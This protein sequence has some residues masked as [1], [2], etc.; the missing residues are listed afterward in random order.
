MRRSIFAA[1]PL[2]SLYPRRQAACVL[3]W[4]ILV[5]TQFGPASGQTQTIFTDADSFGVIICR[6]DAPFSYWCDRSPGS[7]QYIL[8][9][10]Q[11]ALMAGY[12]HF[13]LSGIDATSPIEEARLQLDTISNSWGETTV[14]VFAIADSTADWD[15]NSLSENELNGIKAPFSDYESHAWTGIVPPQQRFNPPTPFL[16]EGAQTDS[17]VRLLENGILQENQDVNTTVDGNAYGGHTNGRQAGSAG[18]AARFDNPWPIKNAVDI[19]ITDVINWKLGQ[20][21]AYSDFA[22]GDRELTIMVRTDHQESGDPNGFVEFVSKESRLIG[23]DVGNLNLQPGRI[24]LKTGVQA[25][26]FNADGRIDAN[27][28]DLLYANLGSTDLRYDLTDDEIVNQSD[29]DELVED[30]LGTLFGDANLDGGR[31]C[32]R[33]KSSGPELACRGC[34]LVAR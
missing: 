26:D 28:I 24:V 32:D 14:S 4:V 12:W 16:G 19:D 33:P 10:D 18:S 1:V 8:V 5:I 23:P 27:D 11:N 20:N 7:E 21:A 30:K 22:P 31:Q 9:Q 3:V 13:D 17:A 25:G 34:G 2:S 29:V 6:N 15:L